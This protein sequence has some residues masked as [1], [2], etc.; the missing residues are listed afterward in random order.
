MDVRPGGKYL[1][2]MRSPEGQEFWSTGVF[3]EIVPNKKLVC[4]DSFSD[5]KGNIIPASDVH[6]PGEWPLELLITAEFE[7]KGGKTK[8]MLEHVGIPAEMHDECV[9]GWQQSFDKLQE[10]VK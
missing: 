6:M 8:I 10:N 2:C 7:E 1:H 4:T 9:T 3:K 5:E